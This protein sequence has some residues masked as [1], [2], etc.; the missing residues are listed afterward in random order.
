MCSLHIYIYIVHTYIHIYIHTGVDLK[1]HVSVFNSQGRQCYNM[2]P[3][4]SDFLISR[5]FIFWILECPFEKEV[6]SAKYAPHSP[7]DDHHCPIKNSQ[8]HIGTVQLYNDIP[9]HK[10]RKRCG[11]NSVNPPFNTIM[12]IIFPWKNHVSSTS[13]WSWPVFLHMFSHRLEKGWPGHG[14]GPQESIQRL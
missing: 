5:K 7:M 11:V 12:F 1:D 14:L 6:W 10:H 8:S 3:R 13:F 4:E 2:I 9:S